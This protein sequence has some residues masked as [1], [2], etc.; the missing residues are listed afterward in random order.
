MKNKKRNLI[1]M[2]ISI[3]II[4]SGIT[5]SQNEK[6]NKEKYISPEKLIEQIKKEREALKKWE[7][8]LKEKEI[9]LKE[10]EKELKKMAQQIVEE[11][12]KLKKEWE[13]L[14]KERR[15]KVVSKKIIKMYET[16]EPQLS[17]ELLLSIY[18][19]DPKFFISI[20][21]KMKPDVRTVIMENI[22]Q[23]EP[24]TA[25]SITN[26]MAKIKEPKK[27]VKK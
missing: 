26:L 9:A 1:A 12:K 27:E 17:S 13:K 15:A 4:I 22:A 3:M 20:L 6:S 24:E 23:K 19:K 18:K 16:M 11:K 5:F 8:R 21:I 7:L 2:L 14:E 25:I 10:W